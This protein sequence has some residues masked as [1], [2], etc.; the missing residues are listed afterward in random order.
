MRIG[1]I[2]LS[3]KMGELDKVAAYYQQLG[4]VI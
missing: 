3:C 2:A 1:H 4:F